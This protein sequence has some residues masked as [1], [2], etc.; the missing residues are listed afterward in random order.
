MS[1][2]NPSPNDNGPPETSPGAAASEGT[3]TNPGPLQQHQMSAVMDDIGQLW[4]A[5]GSR[6]PANTS[7]ASA[8]TPSAPT[9]SPANAP[10]GPSGA[11]TGSLQPNLVSSS[12]ASATP[13][14]QRPSRARAANLGPG[15]H[16]FQ[17]QRAPT[18][19]AVTSTGS[20]IQS[21]PPPQE[22]FMGTFKSTPALKPWD[23][24]CKCSSRTTKPYRHWKYHCPDNNEIE[25]LEC[26]LCGQKI[27]RPDNLTRHREQSCLR[28]R[29]GG[30]EEGDEDEDEE[31]EESA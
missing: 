13:H 23:I 8:A 14:N 3:E 28:I 6:L 10:A 29:E 4:A 2:P 20:L 21:A 5:V 11:A 22:A 17:L 7:G 15:Q 12:G 24:Y 27:G 9:T 1:K 26:E 31:D 19:A 16:R 30:G 18:S 25:D